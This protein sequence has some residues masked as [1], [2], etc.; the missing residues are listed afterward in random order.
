VR[1][2]GE[3]IENQFRIGLVRV[4]RAVRE[5]LTLADSEGLMPQEIPPPIVWKRWWKFI[6]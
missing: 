6:A 5:R 4:E 1:S 3:M 2:V